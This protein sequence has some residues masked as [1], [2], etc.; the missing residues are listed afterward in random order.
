MS[1][2]N[3]NI[4]T[5]ITVFNTVIALICTVMIS[6]DALL[7]PSSPFISKQ[8]HHLN[9]LVGSSHLDA[10]L[11]F[12]LSQLNPLWGLWLFLAEL[13]FVATITNSGRVKCGLT[14]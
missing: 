5:V 10:W 11:L 1:S 4:I 9:T 3:S 7:V 13:R 12:D 14:V 2:L 6:L 8:D